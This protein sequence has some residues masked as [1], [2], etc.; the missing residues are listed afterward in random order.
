MEYYAAVKKNEDDLYELPESNFKMYI[1]CYPLYTKG[2]ITRKYMYIC[3]FVQ[4]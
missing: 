3:S 1:V 4:K 2:E